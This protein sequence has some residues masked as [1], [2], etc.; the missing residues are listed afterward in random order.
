MRGV[1]T[2]STILKLHIPLLAATVLLAA[3]CGGADAGPTV[4]QEAEPA[5]ESE[6]EPGPE[7]ETEPEHETEP[8][9]ETEPAPEPEPVP[10]TDPFDPATWDQ[11]ADEATVR[12]AFNAAKTTFQ[13]DGSEAGYAVLAGMAWPS[14][15]GAALFACNY[16]EDPPT[17][18]ELDTESSLAEY[19][20]SD[21]IPDEGWELP[22]VGTAADDGYR[23][24]LADVTV[25]TSWVIDGVSD[26]QDQSS[27]A[28]IGVNDASHVIWFP[29]CG[30]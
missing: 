21:L 2:W 23:I 30:G 16:P 13:N 28:H 14:I 29:S 19:R 22:S 20:W 1:L 9:P 6:P 18:D 27:S 7:P 25:T 26:Q 3:A 4:A 12:R 11:E 17:Y 15:D 8:E 5:A 10:E 24:Y